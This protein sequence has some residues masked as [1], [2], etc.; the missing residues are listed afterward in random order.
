MYLRY[1]WSVLRHKWYVLKAGRKISVPLWRLLIHDWSKFTPTEFGRYA[2][3]HFSGRKNRQEWAIAWHH[4]LRQNTHHQEYYLL[5]W[6]GEDKSFYAGIGEP[7]ADFLVVL[8]M[9]ESCVREMVADML[10]ASRVYTG[11]WD[12]AS[13]LNAN[14]PKMLLHKDTLDLVNDIMIEMNYCLTNCDWSWLAPMS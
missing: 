11:K 3:W 9:P 7:I 4:H 10:A 8:P 14:G 1:L 6:Y 2:R 13:W 5:G 12:I